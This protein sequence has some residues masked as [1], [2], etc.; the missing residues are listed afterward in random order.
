MV[1]R[2]RAPVLL[3]TAL[4]LVLAAPAGAS[5][6]VTVSVT[7]GAIANSSRLAIGAK[8]GGGGGDWYRGIMDEVSIVLG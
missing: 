1:P 4:A 5:A 2:R 7:I 8:Y 3:V 6:A